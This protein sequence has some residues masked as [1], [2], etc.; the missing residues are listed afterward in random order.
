MYKINKKMDHKVN[1]T[2]NNYKKNKKTRLI[3]NP[4]RLCTIINN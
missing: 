3:H 4:V 2:A 1:K